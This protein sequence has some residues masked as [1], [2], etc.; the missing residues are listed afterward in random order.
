[1]EK[2]QT[3]GWR[4]IIIA[5][6]ILLVVGIAIAVMAIGREGSKQNAD[7]R[8][9]KQEASQAYT[10]ANVATVPIA[11]SWQTVIDVSGSTDQRTAIFTLGSGEKKLLYNYAPN[12]YG[13]CV[14]YVVKEGHSLSEEGGFP[15]V[16]PES[17]GPGET[18]LAQ[19]PGN[20]YLDIKSANCSW[21]VTIQEMK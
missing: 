5:F 4:V 8:E 11:T 18:R 16:S 14:I 9:A 21:Q 3:T 7:V 6:I 1:M 2:K 12:Q 19:G 13:A 15:E 20:Y 10:E 17:A